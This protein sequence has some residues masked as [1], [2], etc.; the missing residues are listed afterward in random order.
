MEWQN[1]K[2]FL[3]CQNCDYERAGGGTRRVMDAKMMTY[4]IRVISNVNRMDSFTLK[5]GEGATVL[6]EVG[7][8]KWQWYEQ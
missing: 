2:Q 4:T 3:T 5:A 7:V 1:C 8:A 6:F